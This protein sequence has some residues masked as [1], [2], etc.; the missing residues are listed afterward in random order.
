MLKVC[1]LAFFLNVHIYEVRLIKNSSLGRTWFYDNYGA[2]R[3]ILQNHLTEVPIYIVL[4]I[5]CMCIMC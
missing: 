1:K 2:V 4:L 3:D 5:V